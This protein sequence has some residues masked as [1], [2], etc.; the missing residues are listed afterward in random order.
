MEIEMWVWC[1]MWE[2]ELVGGNVWNLGRL[3]KGRGVWSVWRE[4]SVEGMVCWCLLL[5]V[6]GG[7]WGVCLLCYGKI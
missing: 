6:D 1:V 7:C 4:W 3:E 2:D 5:F